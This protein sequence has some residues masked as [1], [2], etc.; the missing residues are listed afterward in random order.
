MPL[1][2]A[3]ELKESAP[4]ALQ[5]PQELPEAAQLPK[6]IQIRFIGTLRQHALLVA[7][8]LPQVLA[9]LETSRRDLTLL[10][11]IKILD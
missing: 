6:G 7:L 3:P 2:R 4:P 11:H 8:V 9:D 1:D 5:A 10:I